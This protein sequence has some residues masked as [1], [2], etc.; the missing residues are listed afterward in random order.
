MSWFSDNYEKVII[1]GAAAA[2]VAVTALGF[3]N[4]AELSN[5]FQS[6]PPRKNSDTEVGGIQAMSEAKTALQST[7]EIQ[8]ADID[9][10]KVNLFTGVALFAKKDDMADPV[11]LLKSEPVHAGIPNTWWLDYGIDPG[12]SNSPEQDADEDGFDNRAEHAAETDPVDAESHPEPVA[13]LSVVEVMVEQHHI[14]PQ[15]LGEGGKRALFKLENKYAKRKN[16]MKPQPIGV[17]DAIIFEDPSIMQKRFKFAGLDRRQ[18]AN[19]SEDIIWIIEDLQPNKAGVQYRFDKRG[20]LD[21]YP[22]HTRGIMDYTVK[23]N[24]QAL[25]QDGKTFEVMENSRFS[26]PYDEKAAS[27]PY[28]LKMIDTDAARAEV[29][30]TDGEGNKQLHVMPLK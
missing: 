23:L 7:H 25:G 15:D 30:Y 13:K 10:R 18:N 16:K 2:A 1:G 27:K 22:K 4:K 17:G 29:E 6:A 3:K 21:G 8:Q 5:A 14:K 9:G 20:D 28:L 26:L 24:L 12:F 11:D 19:G